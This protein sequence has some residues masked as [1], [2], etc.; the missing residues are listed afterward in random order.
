MQMQAPTVVNVTFDE[1]SIAWLDEL[2]DR[3]SAFEKIVDLPV[4]LRQ[5][6]R[7]L[8]RGASGFDFEP[9][10]TRTSECRVALKLSEEWIH[11]M[12]ALRTFD[13]GSHA[14]R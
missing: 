3:L 8:P 6:I 11:L 14:V 2:C 5:L 1:D 13:G 9:V 7:D 12:A 10:T 4:K